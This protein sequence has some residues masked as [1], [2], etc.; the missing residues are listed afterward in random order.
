VRI[1]L[2][3]LFG[4]LLSAQATFR[5]EIALVRVDVEVMHNGQLVK[6]LS[7]ADFEVTDNGDVREIRRLRLRYSLAYEMPAGSPGERHDIRIRL[8]AG[9]AERYRK[10]SRTRVPATIVLATR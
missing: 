2:L 8:A 1:G 4:L 7:R 5:S 9:V 3:F 10:R 6:E